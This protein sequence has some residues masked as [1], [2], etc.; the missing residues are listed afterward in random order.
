MNYAPA[1]R[2]AFQR[3]IWYLPALVIT[4]IFAFPLYW[5]LL[6]S[7]KPRALIQDYPPRFRFS[8]V[9]DNYRL[10][11][12]SPYLDA[13]RNSVIIAVGSAVLSVALAT[14][15]AYGLS[16][17]TLPVEGQPALLDS[18]AADVAGD[19]GDH[20]VLADGSTG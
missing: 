20:P 3:F 18:L 13:I 14:L 19:R 8:P 17:Y 5:I 6:T 1:G 7:V 16:R 12:E 15:T 9:W 11:F 4:I 10:V 2:S